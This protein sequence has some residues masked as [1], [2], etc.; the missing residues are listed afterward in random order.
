MKRRVLAAF[1]AMMLTCGVA[2]PGNAVHAAEVMDLSF[3]M[4]ALAA[5]YIMNHS[6]TL[7]NKVYVLPH[8]LDIRI[9]S[10]KLAALGYAIDTLTQEQIDYLT[11]VN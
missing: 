10:I 1:L 9:A 7:E 5:E 3:A 6:T 8:E 11:K 4:Q 2:F